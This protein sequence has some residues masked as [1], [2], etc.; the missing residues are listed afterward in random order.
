MSAATLRLLTWKKDED[1]RK[2]SAARLRISIRSGKF[3]G[4]TP[5]LSAGKL[6]AHIVVIPNR[7][8]HEFQQFCVRNP[9]ACP[10]VAVGSVG[11]PHI[12]ALGDIDLRTDAPQYD[13][14]RFGE[15]VSRKTD[16]TKEWRG[17]FSTFALGSSFTFEN[18][19]IESG[20]ELRHVRMGM[21]VPVYRS[22]IRAVRVGPFSGNIA[23]SMRPIR[24]IDIDKVRA[25][26]VRYPQAHGAPIHIGAPDV[27]G[28]DDIEA[29]EWGDAVGVRDDEVPVFWASGLTA[30]NA[31]QRARPEIFITNAPG[32]MLITDV[33][34]RAD[35]GPF[36]V[37]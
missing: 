31:L 19:L 37:Y 25:I 3:V 30:Q 32:Y 9:K 28:I 5:G 13:V 8:A 7:Y 20:I 16:I 10:L 29:P 26:S 27:I 6:Q 21:K 23:V 33:D 22:S 35:V 34:S 12:R 4:R 2:M 36:K 1:V 15:L 14:Y 17:D 24:R 11:S 18:R